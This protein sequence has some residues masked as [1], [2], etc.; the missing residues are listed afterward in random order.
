VPFSTAA[1]DCLRFTLTS[2]FGSDCRC[3]PCKQLAPKLVAVARQLKGERVVIAKVDAE[4]AEKIAT[5]FGVESYPTLMWY[6]A[7]F[8]IFYCYAYI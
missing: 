2:F 3:G 8:L 7:A 4:A 1:S 5:K 6:R